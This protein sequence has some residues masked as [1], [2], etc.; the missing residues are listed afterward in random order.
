MAGDIGVTVGTSSIQVLAANSGR[1]EARICN[2]SDTQV[3]YIAFGTTAVIGGG[4]R[5][6]PRGGFVDT[7]TLLAINAISTASGG[8]VSGSWA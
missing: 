4:I 7:T 2:D 1:G 8:R 3:I 6:N 5:L